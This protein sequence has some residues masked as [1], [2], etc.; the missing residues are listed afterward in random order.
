MNIDRG[1]CFRS[2]PNDCTRVHAWQTT[3]AMHTVLR[4]YVDALAPCGRERKPRLPRRDQ[5]DGVGGTSGL[6]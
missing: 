5:A 2:E 6:C 4:N 1:S 3:D